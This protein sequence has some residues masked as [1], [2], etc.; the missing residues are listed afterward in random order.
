MIATEL[1]I[2]LALFVFGPLSVLIMIGIAVV[3]SVIST[4]MPVYSIAKKRPVES[5]R[6]L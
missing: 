1:G 5:L 2:P 6:A 3:T 4:F